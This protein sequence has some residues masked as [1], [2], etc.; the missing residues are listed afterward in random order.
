LASGS[1]TDSRR[2]R[3]ASI[4]DPLSRCV[5]ASSSPTDHPF[6]VRPVNLAAPRIV[7]VAGT[8]L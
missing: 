8:S 3:F 4:N 5:T 7:V 6:R 1:T 2:S